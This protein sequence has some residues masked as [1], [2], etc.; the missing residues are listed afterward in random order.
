MQRGLE[1]DAAHKLKFD[2]LSLSRF[3]ATRVIFDRAGLENFHIRV[4]CQLN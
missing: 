2:L 1:V 3:C 4:S